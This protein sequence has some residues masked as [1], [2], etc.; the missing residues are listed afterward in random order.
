[1]QKQKGGQYIFFNFMNSLLLWIIG[2]FL[3]INLLFPTTVNAS[4]ITA[5]KLIELTNQERSK[6]GLTELKENELLKKAAEA[7]AHDIIS[8]Q[9][10]SH[11]FSDKKFSAWIKETGYKYSIVGENLAVNFTSSEP[12]FNAWL[13]S[14]THKKNILHEDYLEI[15]VAS[16]SG[17]WF[18]EETVIVVEM[19]GT[20]AVSSEQLVLGSQEE[21]LIIKNKNYSAYF[22]ASNLSEYY[23]NNIN[24][25]SNSIPN[26]A[27]K[28]IDLK[29]EQNKSSALF[30]VLDSKTV[31][32]YFLIISKL[33]LIYI[34][35]MALVVLIYFYITY[36]FKF[37]KKLQLLNKI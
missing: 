1:M 7:K 27:V 26:S 28:K 18:G 8:Q 35:T 6:Y 37:N 13:A 25:Q 24:S 36:F 31:I 33:M 15:G 4:E 10:F 11:N 9:K 29:N 14:P 5:D 34:L 20:P 21:S 22:I 12:L 30:Y 16:L 3:L 23:L 19:F 17:D 32:N 2:I